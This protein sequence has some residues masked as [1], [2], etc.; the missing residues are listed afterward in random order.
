MHAHSTTQYSIS[1]LADEFYTQASEQHNRQQSHKVTTLAIIIVD[2][3]DCIEKGLLQFY[4]N[5]IAYPMLLLVETISL[6]SLY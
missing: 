3:V 4:S 2:F 1:S 6:L 5:F